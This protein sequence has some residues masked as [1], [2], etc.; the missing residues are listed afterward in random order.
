MPSALPQYNKHADTCSTT[1][2]D[3]GTI[4][5]VFIILSITYWIL[6]FAFSGKPGFPLDD[7]F[8]HLQFARCLFEDGQ[9]AFNKGILSSGSTAPLYPILVAGLYYLV[10]NWYLAS[11]L[12]GAICSLGT[13]FVV[14]G[15]LHSWTGRRD[16]ARWGG[17]LTL[18]MS[19]TIV[20]SFTGMESPVYSLLFLFGIW[21]Y[22]PTQRRRLIAT[23]VFAACIWLRPEFLIMAPIVGIERLIATFATNKRRSQ[24]ISTFLTDILPHILIWI[25]MVSLYCAY[26]WHQDQHLV[27]HTFSAKAIAPFTIRPEYM[28]GLPAAL[29]RGNPVYILLA[30]F[31]W[32][33]LVL[34]FTGVSLGINCAP[35]ACGIRDCLKAVW[36]TNDSATTARRLALLSFVGYPWLRGFVDSVG[37]PLSQFQRYHAHLT[38]LLVLV[39]IA[40][41]PTTGAI[42]QRPRWNWRNVPLKIQQRRTLAWALITTLFTCGW[43]AQSVSN[44]N[45]MQVAIGQWVKEHTQP[46]QLVATNDIGAIGFISQ[47]PILDTIGLVEPPL[48][49][50]ILAG[51][52]VFDYLKD[53]KPAY[54]IIFPNWYKKLLEQHS[55]VLEPVTSFSLNLNL[56]CGGSTMMVYKLKC[57]EYS[58]R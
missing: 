15:I 36:A 31:V 29:H 21:I 35:A 16:L 53:K 44:I 52:D 10:R 38:P 58:P 11:L 49:D 33:L 22:G 28:D 40:A 9:M 57:D 13:T 26:N 55:D 42:I 14:Y 45:S 5:G 4:A 24:A 32:P 7:S 51:G 39:I 30:I 17:L 2:K 41:W 46:D 56:I 23:S 3:L 1:S 54:V 34:F 6:V 47:R 12:L 50:H 37:I 20:Q 43:A 27:P 48:V 8:I 18:L 19:P 25:A